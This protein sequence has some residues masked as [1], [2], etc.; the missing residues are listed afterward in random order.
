MEFKE[1]QQSEKVPFEKSLSESKLDEDRPYKLLREALK[2]IRNT[3]DKLDP[4]EETDVE[5]E[6]AK[7]HNQ[8]WPPYELSVLPMAFS[9]T[10][11]A[12]KDVAQAD[13]QVYKLELEIKL[14]KLT[15]ELQEL[16]NAPSIGKSNEYVICQSPPE[17]DVNKIGLLTGVYA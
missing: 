1:K 15:D 2:E 6:A 16:K 13:M 5:E 8:D 14:Q 12:P 17:R 7:Y 9:V 11:A 10:S 3:D 4:E